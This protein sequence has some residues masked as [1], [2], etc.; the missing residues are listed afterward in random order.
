MSFFLK[1]KTTIN[2]SFVM[3]RF[4]KKIG[5]HFQYFPIDTWQN[6][7]KV[8]NKF[9]FDG[10]EW[11]ISDYSNPIFNPKNIQNIKK[12]LKLYNM[13]ISSV[14]LDF[15]MSEPLYSIKGNNLKWIIKKILYLQKKINIPR[16]TIPI[17]ETCRYKNKNQKKKTL[18]NLYF[19][20]SQ[21]SNKSKISI[22]TDLRFEELFTILNN[23]KFSKL[24]LLIDIGNIRASGKDLEK[25]LTNFKDKIFGIH[26]KYRGKNYGKTKKLPKKFEELSI[27]KKNFDNL[28]NIQDITFQ[29]FRSNN[30]FLSDMKEN[31][32]NF[33][34]V[35]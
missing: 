5:D 17:E 35:F 1:K 19:L 3:G 27:L 31:I 11:I 24:G 23:K 8:G 7:L 22:E 10:V 29:T 6:E 14:A 30:N 33:N 13:K 15:I 20:L 9:G 18:D 28:K 16:I 32:K 26:I 2:Y 25:F 21:L 12:E 34:E 4:S